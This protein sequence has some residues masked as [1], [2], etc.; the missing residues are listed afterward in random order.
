MKDVESAPPLGANAGVRNRNN[1]LPSIKASMGWNFPEVKLASWDPENEK[2]WKVRVTLL[3]LLLLL[4]F[5]SGGSTVQSCL[6]V[7]IDLYSHR[8]VACFS[9]VIT[10]SSHAFIEWW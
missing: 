10:L 8:L 9:F 6:F 3:L 2:Q 4:L 1:K 5:D 7:L